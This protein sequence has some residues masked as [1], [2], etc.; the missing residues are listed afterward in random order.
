MTTSTLQQLLTR[1]SMA[2]LAE[3]GP[4]EEEL[5]QI[6]HAGLL[7]PD[8]AYLRPARLT[9]VSGE[10][11]KRLGDLLAQAAMAED[12]EVTAEQLEKIRLKP[13]RAPLIIVVGCRVKS[14]GKVPEI[15]QV[16]STAAAVSLMQVA[17]D[18]LGYGSMWRTGAM[19]YSG[20]VKRAFGLSSQDHL[21]G[22][23]YVGTAVKEPKKRADVLWDERVS[24][25]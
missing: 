24:T 8:H 17:I 18:A 7:A 23:L 3:P 4:S 12:T 22:F 16:A 9:V 10:G 6:L 15:E 5:K 25:F 13:M 19:A 20:I 1:S 14:H 11:L 2:K 21:I